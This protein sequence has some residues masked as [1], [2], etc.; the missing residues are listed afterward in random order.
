[1]SI[2]IDYFFN[3]DKD[4][5]QLLREIN[6]LLG[7]SLTSDEIDGENSSGV[8]FGML[9]SFSTHTLENDGELNFKDYKYQ[10][11][12]TT[13]WGDADL[14]DTQSLIVDFIAFLLHRRM[15]IS[16]GILVNDVQRLLARYEE[17]II[18]EEVKGLFDK[19]SNKFVE[20]PHHLVELD[21]LSWQ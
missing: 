10:V 9:L 17:K 21:K 3:S 5:K 11:G 16:E 12:L 2:D 4:F 14:R 18:S 8:F 7:C 1:M 19:T 13:Y 6:E 15:Q 20:L